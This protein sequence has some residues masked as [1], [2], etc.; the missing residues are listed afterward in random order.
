MKT[1]LL[2]GFCEDKRVWNEM[3]GYSA[4]ASDIYCLNLPGFGGAP[5]THAL[6]MDEMAAYIK[7]KLLELGIEK[8][9]MIGHSMGGYVTLA[10]AKKYP[11]VLCGFGLFHSSALP[12]T[13]EKKG[14]RLKTI[15]F[16]ERYGA[17]N[18]SRA[19]IPGLFNASTEIGVMFSSFE[20]AKACTTSGLVKATQAMMT[21]DDNTSVLKNS[22]VPVLFV[23]GRKD[24]LI[25]VE[26]TL[27]QVEMCDIS[28]MEILEESGHMGMLEEPEKSANIIDSFIAFSRQMIQ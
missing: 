12:D 8:C 26:V 3:L 11:D 6:S 15:D 14:S 13:E 18:Y 10:F 5:E 23:M 4:N 21:R 17:E 27:N 19:L 1:V 16:I 28:Q 20:I 9:L 22:K 7:E 24:A 25:P 2:H